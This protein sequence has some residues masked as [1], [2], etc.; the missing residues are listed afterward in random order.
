MEIDQSIDIF[1]RQFSIT[2]SL[3]EL[4]VSRYPVQRMSMLSRGYDIRCEGI[5]SPLLVF[6]TCL[7]VAR[8]IRTVKVSHLYWHGDYCW[9]GNCVTQS[10]H[11]HSSCNTM[12]L[13]QQQYQ[14]VVPSLVKLHAHTSCT[15]ASH[16]SLTTAGSNPNQI[17]DS[18]LAKLF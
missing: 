11:G 7:L 8:S 14:D 4:L 15:H 1:G 9:I 17:Q 5:S 2:T 6:V 13:P 12:L 16:Y 18:V 10:L 3:A